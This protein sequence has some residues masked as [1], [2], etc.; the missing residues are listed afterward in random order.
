L[1]NKDNASSSLDSSFPTK[2]TL[3]DPI[4]DIIVPPPEIRA[5]VNKTSQFVAKN[6]RQFE[7]RILS[8]SE[9]STPKFSFMSPTSPYHPYY[10]S[11]ISFFQ[12]GGD[13]GEEER[14]IQRK[15]EEDEAAHKEANEKK[16]VVETVVEESTE[17]KAAVDV[18]GR[19]VLEARRIMEEDRKRKNGEEKKEEGGD[20]E[21][22]RK[23]KTGGEERRGEGNVWLK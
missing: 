18:V 14:E 11:R 13:A 6:G 4:D 15:R 7:S 17:M 1:T 21:E 20:E 3:D 10:Q 9:G 8:S 2:M 23:D 22:V 16:E 5:V 19:A 12:D